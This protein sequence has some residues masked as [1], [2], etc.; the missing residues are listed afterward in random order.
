MIQSDA[1]LASARDCLNLMRQS[2]EDLES[3]RSQVHPSNF[4]LLA[5]PIRDE[6]ARF[7]MEIEDCLSR[8]ATPMATSVE[9]IAPVTE[10]EIAK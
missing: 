4:E 10:R 8:Q 5:E 1:G 9:P 2:L 6:I 7:E 3:K